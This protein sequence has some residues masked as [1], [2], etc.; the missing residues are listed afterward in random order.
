MKRADRLTVVHVG[1]LVFLVALVV[2]AGKVQL[3]DNAGWAALANRQHF[4]PA[5]LPAVRGPIVDA[6]GSLLVESRELA[7]LSVA[8]HEVR[9]LRALERGLARAGVSATT[10]RRLREPGRRWV[11]I[12]NA[13]PPADIAPLLAMRGVYTTPVV[14]RVYAPSGGIRRIVGRL[15]A[16]GR[17]LDGIELAF[18]S[19]LR[20]DSARFRVARDRFG[21]AMPGPAGTATVPQPGATV[22]LTINRTLQD[23]CE[24]ALALAVDTLRASGGDIVVLH[25]HTGEVLAMASSRRD[26]SAT[27]NTAISEP[28]EPGSTLKPFIAAALLGRGRA[29]PDDIV[30]THNGVL[31]IEGRTVHDIHKAEQ[32][33]LADVIRHSSNIG[34][35]AFGER[36]S[37]REKYE[38][39]RDLG[40]GSPTGIPLP[41]E[42]S[43]TLRY[44]RLWSRQ[45]PASLMMGYEIAV[46]PLQLAAAYAS[47]ANGGLI[48]EPQLVREVRDADGA[49]LFRARPRVLRRVFTPAAAGAARDM[50][51][52][53]VQSGTAMRADLATYQLGGKS[54]T[55]RRVEAGRY[56]PGKYTASFVGLF[57][58]NDPQYVVL[59]KLDD[60]QSAIFGGQIAAP[61]GRVVLEAALAA[62]DAALDRGSLAISGRGSLDSFVATSRSAQVDTAAVRPVAAASRVAVVASAPPPPPPPSAQPVQNRTFDVPFV[63]S[64]ARTGGL[65]RPVPD[66][67]GASVRAAVRALHE[68]GFRVVVERGGGSGAVTPAPGTV[69]QPGALVRLTVH[70]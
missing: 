70:P 32:L 10:L 52:S 37:S 63:R 33:S 50:L 29:R 21:R 46:T 6:S 4:S 54:G 22:T 53:V 35:I 11:E 69:L 38:L 57:P 2:R 58:A 41:A 27:A 26:P 15:D 23:I 44:P 47:L 30:P 3:A 66:V 18:D 7:R 19:L 51:V 25:P 59:V 20:G 17:P 67:N 13:L 1:L 14:D 55:A 62:R 43:G 8:P 65:P 64:P 56:A 34:I 42:A 60:P 5:A 12:P 9:D 68:A 16:A 36:L 48:L 24:R 45:S 31:E 61:L 39:F 40:F 28:F 49:V